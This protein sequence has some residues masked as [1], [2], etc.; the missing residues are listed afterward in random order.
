MP[1]LATLAWFGLSLAAATP[2]LNPLPDANGT[3]NQGFEGTPR[4]TETASP[5]ISGAGVTIAKKEESPVIPIQEPSTM[6]LSV[7]GVGAFAL[8]HQRKRAA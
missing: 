6:M 5:E 4:V 8:R 7:L 3:G 2:V 1:P